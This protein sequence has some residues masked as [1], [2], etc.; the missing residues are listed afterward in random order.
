MSGIRK[1]RQR[2]RHAAAWTLVIFLT[3]SLAGCDYLEKRRI[4]RTLNDRAKALAAGDTATYL[5]FFS[6]DYDDPNQSFDTIKK[7]VIERLKKEPRPVISFGKREINIQGDLAMVTERFTL[8]DALEGKAMRYDEVQHL[9]LARGPGGW[10]CRRGSEVLRL[11]SGRIEEERAIEETLLRREAA[12]V[13]EDIKSYMNLVSPRY[14]HEGKS[15]EDVRKKV[16]QNFRVYDDIQFRSFDRK[17]WYFGDVATV[18]QRF[19]MHAVQMGNP[20]TFSGEERFEL[21][22]TPDGWKFTQGL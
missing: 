21:E 4:E 8:E 2:A 13:K 18:Q 12:L 6:S 15:A 3:L 1:S 20:M 16:L 7:K 10:V 14:K 19:T 22:K 5:G 11:L 17:I 9:L